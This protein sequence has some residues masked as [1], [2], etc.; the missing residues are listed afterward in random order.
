MGAAMTC[1]AQGA[2]IR[3]RS[4][5]K[6]LN[7]YEPYCFLCVIVLTSSRRCRFQY[8][9]DADGGHH[10]ELE[11]R[12]GRDRAM[13]KDPELQKLLDALNRYIDDM[14]LEGSADYACFTALWTELL[15]YRPVIPEARKPRAAPHGPAPEALDR[16]FGRRLH[17]DPGLDPSRPRPAS[18]YVRPSQRDR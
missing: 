2:P 12:A 1:G 17:I 8:L 15:A 10:A 16:G 6:F 5:D 9:D 13:S 7:K 11:L 4:P 3:P 14:P 18:G